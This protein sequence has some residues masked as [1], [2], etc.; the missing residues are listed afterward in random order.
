VT[1]EISGYTLAEAYKDALFKMRV[2]GRDAGSRAGRVLTIEDP[3]VLTLHNPDSRVLRD[4]ERDA[5]PFFH[6]METV[7][8][9]AGYPTTDW[10]KQ[11]NKRIVEFAEDNGVING[12]YGYR[13]RDRGV[14][15]IQ[16]A[17]QKLRRDFDTRQAVISM[18]DPKLDNCIGKRDYP[19]NT[20]I[21][22]RVD[23]TK[24]NMTVCNRSNDLI[25]GMLGANVVHMTYLQE[26]VAQMAGL[27]LGKYQVFTNNLHIYERHW[28]LL[29]SPS[30]I[31]IEDEYFGLAPPILGNEEKYGELVFD[32][33]DLIEGSAREYNTEWV[34][35]VAAPIQDLWFHRKQPDWQTYLEKIGDEGWKTSCREWIL[36]RLEYTDDQEKSLDTTQKDFFS[37]KQ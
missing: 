16:E 26:L 29:D 20:H 22:F 7:W 18:W 17:V 37:E 8:M 15:Q 30:K 2:H 27:H 3:V 21:Y 19:C 13:W 5:N 33:H 9:I 6:V 11:F 4:P 28:H 12:A 35:E 36:R 23:K 32:C 10:L 34:A 24:L 25:W 31:E 14:D 1:V